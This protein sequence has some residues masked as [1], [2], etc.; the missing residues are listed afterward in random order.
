[1]KCVDNSKINENNQILKHFFVYWMITHK[2][3]ELFRSMFTS[4]SISA[5]V[6]ESLWWAVG[7]S[8]LL[9]LQPWSAILMMQTNLFLVSFCP[10]HKSDILQCTCISSLQIDLMFIIIRVLSSGLVPTSSSYKR[11]LIMCGKTSISGWPFL[12]HHLINA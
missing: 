5:S 3:Q 1:M 9:P 4:T 2:Q 11:T 6:T 7:G 10:L 8:R 12:L